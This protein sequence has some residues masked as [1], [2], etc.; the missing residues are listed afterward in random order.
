MKQQSGGGRGTREG[1]GGRG[2]QDSRKRGWGRVEKAGTIKEGP[3]GG[4]EMNAK[5]GGLSN[6]QNAWV[7]GLGG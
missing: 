5:T 7:C 2:W 6:P 1:L 4:W 3:A